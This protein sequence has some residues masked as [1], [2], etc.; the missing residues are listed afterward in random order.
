MIAPWTIVIAERGWIFAGPMSRDGDRITFN[1]GYIVR[2]F[3]IETK[4]G[5]GALADRG[6]TTNNDVLDYAPRGIGVYVL[7]V[8]GDFACDQVAWQKFHDARI[9]VKR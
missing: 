8:L 9:K 3:S 7:G 2:R 6:P 1:P 4:D 5:L